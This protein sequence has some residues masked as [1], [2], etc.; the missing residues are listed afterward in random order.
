MRE[1]PKIAKKHL[2]F[3]LKIFLKR[4]QETHFCAMMFYKFRTPD[5]DVL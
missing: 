3:H 5:E 4:N 2:T 1:L